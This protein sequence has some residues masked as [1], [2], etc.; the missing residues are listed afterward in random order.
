MEKTDSL[1]NLTK[2]ELYG[3]YQNDSFINYD[4]DLND[5]TSELELKVKKSPDSR[6]LNGDA[7]GSTVPSKHQHSLHH[8]HATGFPFIVKLVILSSSAF[9][10][11]EIIRHI[12]YN[13]F[14]ENQLVN[15]PLSITH[16]FL[17]SI[18]SKFKLGTY[19]SDIDEHD[20]GKLFD[21][22]FALTLQGL[23][24]ASVHPI[25]DK[26]LP[27]IFTKRLLSSNPASANRNGTTNFLNDLIRTCVTFLGISYAIRKIEWTSF[28]QVSII[29]SLI[30][31]G[32]WLLLDGTIS[33][34]LSSLLV[35]AGCCVSIYL[36]NARFILS[37]SKT[38]NDIIALWL[39]T[40]SFFFCGIIIFGKLG[41]GL[42]GNGGN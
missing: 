7:N 25:L 31:P 40:G 33:G 12:N 22:I 11:N 17:Y 21:K 18:V 14:S 26:V 5:S 27:S 23:L 9:L 36:Q 16:V 39:W 3:F 6:Y 20:L 24:M 8:P 30:N 19:I 29:W 38:T 41:R 32:L 37:Y 10:Y 13:H 15:F 1:T 35:T 4:K 42:F 34:F 28:L 2:P